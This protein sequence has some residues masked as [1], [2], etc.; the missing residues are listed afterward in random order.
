[1]FH[2][3]YMQP[4][5]EMVFD[6]YALFIAVS[7]HKMQFALCG[8]IKPILYLFCNT[9]IKTAASQRKELVY[10]SCEELLSPSARTGGQVTCD[11]F[12]F[13]VPHVCKILCKQLLNSLINTSRYV[14][15][16]PREKMELLYFH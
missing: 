1:M 8:Q 5:N 2:L 14:L 4:S 9:T 16:F 7:Y 6:D 15:S 11:A 13:S 3:D 12:S 10:G